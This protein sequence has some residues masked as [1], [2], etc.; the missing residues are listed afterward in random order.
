MKGLNI[1]IIIGLF[2]STSNLACADRMLNETDVTVRCAVEPHFGLEI[3]EDELIQ[4]LPDAFPGQSA[5]GQ[6]HIIATSNRAKPWSIWASSSG[7]SGGHKDNHEILPIKISTYREDLALQGTFF[8]DVELSEVPATIYACD[9]A[10]SP[11]ADLVLGC[12]FLIITRP[13]TREDVY[14]GK[15]VLTLTE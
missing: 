7:L 8:Q 1:I 6:I 12:S 2:L 3:W 14:S 5:A 13:S 10:E 4:H 11:C 9:E 15:I